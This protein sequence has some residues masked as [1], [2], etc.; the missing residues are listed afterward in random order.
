MDDA[1]I[2]RQIGKMTALSEGVR[3][4]HET[5]SYRLRFEDPDDIT[6]VAVRD[7]LLS[8]L[9]SELP[10]RG[11]V[12]TD[13]LLDAEGS[14]DGPLDALGV[15]LPPGLTGHLREDPVFRN[16]VRDAVT[17]QD[18]QD[19]PLVIRLLDLVASPAFRLSHLFAPA[20]ES[21]RPLV[22]STP[23]FANI[24]RQALQDAAHAAREDVTPAL[25]M[26]HLV[27]IRDMRQTVQSH[28]SQ[29]LRRSLITSDYADVLDFTL[30]QDVRKLTSDTESFPNYVH[31]CHVLDFEDSH[32]P[33]DVKAA[34]KTKRTIELESPLFLSHMRRKKLVD[35]DFTLEAAARTAIIPVFWDSASRD[36]SIRES[37]NELVDLLLEI[38]GNDPDVSVLEEI[39]D[40]TAFFNT[41]VQ[42]EA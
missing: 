35:E 38:F 21:L 5:E 36:V 28:V 20:A 24:V 10:D 12:L 13:S 15:L 11:L 32:G 26:A 17:D 2:D 22:D 1:D 40:L 34:R 31:A 37:Y 19:D 30:F 7:V 6:D 9:E 41:Y 18:G 8:Q 33:E 4:M 23:V 3:E 16:R 27:R 42:G 39:K 29:A 25:V 14:L